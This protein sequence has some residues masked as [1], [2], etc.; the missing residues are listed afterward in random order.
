MGKG[1]KGKVG[2]NGPNRGANKMQAL[3]A[4]QVAFS[5]NVAIQERPLIGLTTAVL[6]NMAAD[7]KLASDHRRTVPG[8]GLVGGGELVGDLAMARYFARSC[9]NSNGASILGGTDPAALSHVDQ[10]V[11]YATTMSRLNGDRRVRAISA[12]LDHHLSMRT[13]V[14]HTCSPTL[15]DLA[16]FSAMQWPA[17]HA[18]LAQV[19][20][21]LSS[22]SSPTARWL[23]TMAHHPAV[24]EATQLAVGIASNADAY[25]TDTLITGMNPL[26]GATPGRVCT[27]FPPEPSGYLH[28]GHAKAVLLN[29]YYAR[30]YKGKLIVRFDDTNPSKEKEEYQES[31]MSDLKD[32]L[33]IHPEAFFTFT[34]DYFGV[35]KGYAE[36]L[37]D[38]HMVFMDDTPQDQMQKERMDRKES[39]HRNQ[40][41]QDCKKLFQQMC[42]G[43]EEGSKWCLRVRMD[44]ASDNGT[45]RDPVIYRQNTTPHHRTGTKYH[46]YP[47]YDLACPIVDSIEGVTHALRTT[48]YNDRDEQY[49]WIQRLLNLRRV[50][51]HAFA[52]MNFMYTELSK[53]KLAWFVENGHV[54]GWDDARFPTIRGVLRRGVHVDALRTFICSQGASRR[55]T[56]ME[57]NK[58]WA[59]NK[60]EIDKEAKRFM[61]IAK[62]DHVEL[63]IENGSDASTSNAFV[64]TEYLPKNPNF[65]K[66]VVRVGNKVILEKMDMD[67]VQVGEE[68]VL[69]RWGVVK[70]TQVEPSL[71][72]N[73]IPDGDIKAAKRKLSWLTVHSNNTPCVLTEFDN[74]LSKAKLEPEDDFKDHLNPNTEATSEVIGDAGLKTLQKNSIIQLE[75]RGYYR[76][77]KPYVSKENPLVLFMVPDGKA[78]AMSGLQGKLAHR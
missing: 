24:R 51:I 28:I 53:R 68:I 12:T 48:E 22:P 38:N 2:A 20:S 33:K 5:P 72:G 57:W 67:G 49:A 54:A 34:S 18:D 43:S 59:E 8:L 39:K 32:R 41:V 27:R 9:S 14:C 23:H 19:Q 63:E 16:L 75:R 7:L 76:V 73:Y 1:N 78:K 11:D 60:K 42:S 47:T 15:A 62:D 37:I 64:L 50:R 66:R 3:S 26:E 17:Q 61:A 4:M 6:C 45:L 58:F 21:K 31:I 74:L 10:W 65:G 13:F 71:K 69:M 44:M 25:P 52:R 46:A 35:I 56:N 36:Y 29:D 70:L 77:D 55:I 30:H 40:S